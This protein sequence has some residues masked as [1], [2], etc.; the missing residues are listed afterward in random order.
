MIMKT[1]FV[2]GSLK[3]GFANHPYVSDQNLISTGVL[4][5][6]D[7]FNLGRFPALKE[8]QGKVTGEVYEVDE[9]TF[10]LLDRLE[11]HPTMYKRQENLVHLPY[12][13]S[14]EAW[15]YIYQ[16]T[17]SSQEQVG[18]EWKHEHLRK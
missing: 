16:G 11:G 14:L 2:Y 7:M 12:G 9:A 8:G 17:V 1:V 13:D 10:A 18:E 6:F 15:V 3:K 5:G 4:Y